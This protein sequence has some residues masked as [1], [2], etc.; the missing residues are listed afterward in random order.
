[1]SLACSQNCVAF[2]AHQNQEGN[3]VGFDF[4]KIDGS[5]ILTALDV[6]NTNIQSLDGVE[7]LDMLVELYASSND[8][9]GTFPDEVL[10]LRHLKRLD[11]SFNSFDGPLPN[12]IGSAFEKI[13]LLAL[14]HNAFSG[15]LPTS[16]GQLSSLQSLQLQ[17]NGLTG[18]LPSFLTLS[19]LQSLDLS[20]NF[21]HSTVPSD[22]LANVDASN[23]DHLD[24]SSNL[25]TGEL[26]DS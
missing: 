1:L 10:Q 2:S 13:Q 23:F 14:H 22:L 8:W 9:R 24:L 15:E 16:L 18:T 26:P 6:T 25:L 20:G 12:D 7:H 5:P 21:L 11:L 3:D 4:E 19:L 17:A